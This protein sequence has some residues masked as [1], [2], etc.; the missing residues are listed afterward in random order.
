M[1]KLVPVLSG[2][3]LTVQVQAQSRQYTTA[4]AHSHNDYERSTP[5]Y[6]A[7]ALRFGS[8]EADIH[9]KDSI[10]YVAHD[11][12][13]IQPFRTFK[14]LYILP[15]VRQFALNNG[16][17]YTDGTP[18]Q[19]LV[20]IKT[21]GKPTL[22]ALQALL[23]PYRQYFDR[24]VNPNA[25]RIVLSGNIPATADWLQYDPLFFFDGRPDSVYPAA[26][27]SRVAMVSTDFHRFSQWNGK[28]TLLPA[29][30]TKVAAVVQKAHEQGF[31]FRFWGAPSSRS[32]YYKLMDLGVDVIGTDHPEELYDV[33][34]H[35]NKTTARQLPVHEVYTPTY[36]ADATQVKSKNVILMI[37]DGTGLA[38]MFAGYT[39]NKGDLNIFRMRQLGLSKTQS[40]DNYHTDSAAGG[41]AMGTGTKT[42]NREIGMDNTYVSVPVLPELLAA[43]GIPSGVIVTEEITGATPA[44]FYGHTAD[45]DN[46]AT[47]ASQLLNSPLQLAVGGG[48]EE[49]EQDLGARLQQAGVQFYDNLDS[50]NTAVKNRT[51][52]ILSNKAVGSMREGR[53]NYL[54]QALKK[55]LQ[56]LSASGKGFFLMVEGSRIDH[57]GHFNDLDYLVREMLDFDDAVG[58]ALRFADENKQTTVIVTADHETGGLAL[59]DGDIATGQLRGHFATND[60]TGIPVMVFAYGPN[61][62]LFRGV[63]ENNEIFKKMQRCFGL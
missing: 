41:S 20:D 35:T 14:E 43:K 1:K 42:N 3:L 48:K 55:A 9:L 58:T 13:D 40:S 7:A 49:L 10:L 6:A 22:Q 54:K 50:W 44:S 39:A 16:K 4:Q 52:V 30:Q 11:S 51:L 53:G 56:Q 29:E 28:G 33:I 59:M 60:H 38:Q 46:T 2:I 61:S 47:L 57:G 45:R 21:E 5:F 31:L 36:V 32:C 62:G 23:Q 24:S 12:K 63:Y 18:L 8:I 17:V 25:V 37:G 15:V 19:L 34:H 26:L 27:K